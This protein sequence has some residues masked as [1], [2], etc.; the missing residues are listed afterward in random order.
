MNCLNGLF[1]TLLILTLIFYL[2]GFEAKAD[3]LETQSIV[4]FWQLGV[5]Q[6][7]IG[8]Y[9]EAIARFTQA[10]EL[11]KDFAAAYSNRCLAYL[12]LQD[13]QNAIADCNQAIKLAPRN[14]EA[15]INRGTAYYREGDYPAAIN[16]NNEV[17]TNKPDD[18]RAYYNRGVATAAL[19]DYENAILD[20]HRALSLIPQTESNFLADIYNDL[21][22][23]RFHLTDFIAAT[24][25]F[26]FAIRL[27]PQDYRAY[28]NRGCTCGKNGDNVGAVR[29]FSTT[30]D[31]NP[32][33]AQAYINRGIA[34]HNLGYE[35]AA[36]SDL[37]IAATYFGQ[38]GQQIAYQKTLNL[39][40]IVQQQIPAIAQTG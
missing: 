23:A 16:D 28:F 11:K 31:L 24:R 2:L 1:R 37:Q 32:S 7:Q 36:I 9:S 15:Y 25:N 12:Q 22:L 34:Y 3:V 40:K 8:N 39:I 19:G 26:N 5:Q 33:N 29:D 14:I 21:G 17:I 35:Q 6:L 20:Y 13:Y 18:F 30:V 38:Q 10:I 4:D 27:N